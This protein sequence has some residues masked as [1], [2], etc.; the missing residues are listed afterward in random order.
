MKIKFLFL[1][2]LIFLLGCNPPPKNKHVLAKINNYEITLDEFNEAFKESPYAYNDSENSKK[3]FLNN[4]IYRK[5]LLQDAQQKGL[6][7]DKS[8]L[9]MIE[10]FWEQSL[11]KLAIDRKTREV[12]GTVSVSDK[13]IE[14]AYNSMSKEIKAGKTYEQMYQQIKWEITRAKETKALNDW[15]AWL[16]KNADIKVNYELLSGRP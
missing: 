9:K 2:L 8:F 1:F 3:D 5:L 12:A 11:L 13:E 15:V 14:D 4:L 10:K 6:D 7:R 16:R